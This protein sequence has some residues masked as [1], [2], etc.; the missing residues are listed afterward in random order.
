MSRRY[1]KPVLPILNRSHPLARGLQF[2]AAPGAVKGF[3]DANGFTDKDSITGLNGAIQGSL[4]PTTFSVSDIG[5]TANAGASQDAWFWQTLGDAAATRPIPNNG[6]F[7]VAAL[8][9]INTLPGA[10]SPAIHVRG[11]N[12]A[13][14]SLGLRFLSSSPNR[15]DLFTIGNTGGLA[16]ALDPTAINTAES[17]LFVGTNSASAA[18]SLFRNGLLQATAAP[19]APDAAIPRDV[20]TSIIGNEFN[21]SKTDAQIGMAA[22]W[23]Y[24]LPRGA[25]SMLWSDPYC[26]WKPSRAVG[27]ARV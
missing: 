19:G 17:F 1:I 3:G 6:R 18:L 12:G 25:I 11:S 27:A 10:A 8:F 22:M 23:N 13:D 4:D 7:S 26:L 15:V 21:F 14:N 20:V 24:V 9:R 2:A 5:R 16:E